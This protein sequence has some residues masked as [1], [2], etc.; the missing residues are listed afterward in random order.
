M[1]VLLESGSSGDV[2]PFGDFAVIH[3]HFVARLEFGGFFDDGIFFG[4]AA[5]DASRKGEKNGAAG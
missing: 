3:I 2:F 4:D 1:V 5:A